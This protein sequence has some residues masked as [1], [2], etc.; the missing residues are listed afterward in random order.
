[1]QSQT[2][3][4]LAALLSVGVPR[5]E[6]WSRLPFPSPGDRPD[7]GI[8]PVSPAVA[9]GFFTAEPPRKSRREERALQMAWEGAECDCWAQEGYR[10]KQTASP[11]R[12][13]SI[14][15]TPAVTCVT[16]G[17]IAHSTQALGS[18]PILAKS[19]GLKER[20]AISNTLRS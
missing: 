6:Y 8:K 11:M 2:R 12:D 14:Q 20:N 18:N 17:S 19:K 1:M 10:N 7:P 9:G 3:S 5:Q 4:D 13:Y 16:G 15:V